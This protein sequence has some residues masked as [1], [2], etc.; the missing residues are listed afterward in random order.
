MHSISARNAYLLCEVVERLELIRRN[1]VLAVCI[2]VIGS[3]DRE[4]VTYFRT[5]CLIERNWMLA[6]AIEAQRNQRLRRIGVT[7]G[8]LL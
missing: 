2:Q 7:Q 6:N 3:E 1:S 5:S 4:Y 8:K